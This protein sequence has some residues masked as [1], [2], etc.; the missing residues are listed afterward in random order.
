MAFFLDR[1]PDPTYNFFKS[2]L[3]KIFFTRNIRY[4]VAVGLS[5]LLF[6]GEPVEFA[7]ENVFFHGFLIPK[8]V[9]R[10]GLGV[11]L[12]QIRISSS[13]GMKVYEVKMNYKLIADDVGEV[14]IKGQ[15]EKLTEKFLIRVA[16]TKDIEEAEL[17]AQELRTKLAAKVSVKTNTEDRIDGLYQVIVGDFLTRGDALRFIITLNA[18]GIKDTWIVQEEVTE[19]ESQPLWI[20]IN[21]ELKSLSDETVLYFI[22]SHPRSFLSF[23]GRDYRGILVLRASRKGIVL[24]NILNLDNYL[25]SVVPSELSPYTFNELEAQKAQAVAARTYAFKNLN[26]YADIGYDLCDTPKSQFYQGMNAENPLSSRAVEET[27]GEVAFYKGELIDALYT[28]TCGGMTEDVEDVF[29]GPALSYLRSTECVYE[30]QKEWVLESKRSV[31]PVYVQGRDVSH[32]LA[33]LMSLGIIPG[34]MDS[35]SFGEAASCEEF[36][37][38]VHKALPLLGKKERQV[39]SKGS[40]LDYQSFADLVFA[41]FGWQERVENLMLGSEMTHVLKGSAKWDGEGI[42]RVAYLIREGIFPDLPSMGHPQKTMTRGEA[43]FYL[44]KAIQDHPD[45]IRCGIFKGYAEGK[46]LLEEQKKEKTLALAPHC[47]LMRNFDGNISFSSLLRLLGGE[48]IKWVEREGIIL[49]LE[50]K[51]PPYSNILDRNSVVHRWKVRQSKD[52]LENHINQYYPIGKLQDLIPQRR[53]SSKRV[54]ELLILGENSQVVVKGLRIRSVL[55]LRETLFVID[56][57][58]DQ[59][60]LITHFNFSGRGWGH[61]VGL[62]QVGAYGMALSGARYIDI[63]KKYYKGIQ[64]KRAY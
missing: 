2:Q 50:V 10:V 1:E 63:L 49:L 52:K 44:W 20:L 64:I 47:H 37:V 59:K 7:Q 54:V 24:V 41:A 33:T 60:G 9:I 46:V 48:E 32:E 19:E 53:G 61:G 27:K 34:N 39:L 14:F 16:Q 11:N 45:L 22:P 4:V 51:Y 57:E 43:A 31:L 18:A 56:R 8:P 23:K 58:Y 28:S 30:K 38:W 26:K 35:L 6:G 12:S 55:G 29:E 21:D 62:C 36:L 42:G 15:K 13:A 40:A 5:F 25:K 17:L 3:M